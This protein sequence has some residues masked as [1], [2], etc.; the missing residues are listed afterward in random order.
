M[1]QFGYTVENS[2]TP[3]DV[4]QVMVDLVTEGKWGGGT[5]LECTTT[6]TRSLG[7][8]NID[9][10]DSQGSSVPQ[11]FIDRNQA[12]ITAALKKERGGR[13]YK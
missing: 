11:E 9:P 8:W 13:S 6:G 3:D 4:A 5:V 12:P 10:P 2:I 1:K 7:T